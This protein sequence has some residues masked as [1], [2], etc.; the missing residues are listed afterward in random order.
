[1]NACDDVRRRITFMENELRRQKKHPY[2][3]KLVIGRQLHADV[4]RDMSETLR[5]SFLQRPSRL[6]G[7]PV[8][9]MDG[10][11]DQQYLALV[12]EVKG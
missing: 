5:T 12:H 4:V 10:A 6:F 3:Y 2:G 7:Y 11:R 8:A 9:F 1:M